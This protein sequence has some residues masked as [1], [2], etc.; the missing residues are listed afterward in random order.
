MEITMKRTW[1]WALGLLAQGFFLLGFAVA[2]RNAEITTETIRHAEDLLGLS[3]DEPKRNLMLNTLKGQ[4][5]SLNAIRQYTPENAIPPAVFYRAVPQGY[6]VPTGESRLTLT[7]IPAV[8]R[9]AK[10]ADLAFMSIPQLASLIQQKKISSEELTLFYLNRLKT[11]DDTLRCVISYTEQ[12]ALAMARKA[13]AEIAAG[14]YKGPLHGIPYGLKDL[15]AVEGYRTTWGA[16]PYRDQVIDATAE[17][18]KRLDEAGAVL[19]AKLTLGALAM[20]DVWFD[21]VTKNPWNMQQSSSG[22]SAGS[23]SAVAAGLVPF[24]IGTE[25]LGSIVSPSTRCGV[26]GLRPS[27]GRVSRTGGM[28]L[29][30]SMDKVGPITRSAEDAAIV[31]AAI[32]GADGFDQSGVDT[33]FVYEGAAKPAG[34]RVGYIKSFFDQNYQGKENDLKVLDDLR[35]LG[36][37][38]V[39]VNWSFDMPVNAMRIILNAE[40]GAAF[41]ELT[42]S[43]RDSLLVAQGP[44]AWPNT[45]R[46]SRF[47]PAAEYINANRIRTRLLNEVHALMRDFDVVVTPSFGGNQLLVTNLTGHP[48]VVVRNGFLANGSPTS[49]SFLGNL[50]EDHKP[51]ALAQAWQEFDRGH[52]LRPS[53]FNQ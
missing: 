38:L 13:D 1:I 21:G 40:A 7:P 39:E 32:H 28:A 4:V 31:F 12:R 29:S 50:F 46:S 27:F 10:D 23:A 17:V 41:D 37:D 47:I 30:W 19:V 51:L 5:A 6:R 42:R 44:G 49:I 36:F 26:T 24:A 11:Y 43:G 8:E 25:T 48:C 18:V 16:N 45:F 34:W 3:F 22:S 9:P 35:K 53:F 52:E 14:R 33:P 15:F 20:G 2:V